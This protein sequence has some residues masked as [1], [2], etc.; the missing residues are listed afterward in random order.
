MKKQSLVLLLVITLIITWRYCRTTLMPPMV[1][2]FTPMRLAPVGMIGPGAVLIIFRTRLP[3]IAAAIQLR[4]P[5]PED[6][7][8]FIYTPIPLSTPLFMTPSIS[9]LMAVQ[10][11]VKAL[12]LLSSAPAPSMSSPRPTPGLK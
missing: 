4:L 10:P 6:G 11:A 9:L 8:A 7:R 12:T 5:I 3:S 1:C 2:R